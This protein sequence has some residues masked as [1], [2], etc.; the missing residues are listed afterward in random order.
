MNAYDVLSPQRTLAEWREPRTEAGREAG[1]REPG[2]APSEGNGE[3]LTAFKQGGTF[4]F[5]GSL[6]VT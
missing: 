4:C 3:L 6:L 1:V 5:K 2:W